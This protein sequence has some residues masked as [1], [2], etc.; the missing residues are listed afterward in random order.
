MNR[1]PTKISEYQNIGNIE[2]KKCSTCM[3]RKMYAEY[4]EEYM[5]DHDSRPD[6]YL[7]VIIKSGY[8][9]KLGHNPRD[10]CYHQIKGYND[11][12]K[13]LCSAGW[14]NINFIIENKKS[15]RIW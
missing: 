7:G 2:Y 4:A 6:G 8:I 13:D 12:K 15:D 1:F 9:C 10:V 3:Y 5:Y 14:K 11:D